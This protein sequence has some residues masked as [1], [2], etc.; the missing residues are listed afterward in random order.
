MHL[1]PLG[2]GFDPFENMPLICLLK[3]HK[4]F[5]PQERLASHNMFIDHLLSTIPAKYY[6][7]V[8]DDET[9]PTTNKYMQNPANTGRSHKKQELKL[10]KKENKKA[11]L[12]PNKQKSIKELQIEID[13]KQNAPDSDN[14]DDDTDETDET[15]ED[16]NDGDAADIGQAEVDSDDHDD[17]STPMPPL[18]LARIQSASLQELRERFVGFFY[19]QMFTIA[20]YFK[21]ISR[22]HCRIPGEA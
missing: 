5:A 20:F 7:V 9:T 3:L 13:A 10:N 4:S 11:R 22:S 14:D 2:L 19:M 16:N 8:D 17:S 21:Q 12:D 6:I 1:R 15:D 18:N